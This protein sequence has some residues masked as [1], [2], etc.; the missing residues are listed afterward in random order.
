[1]A[2]GTFQLQHKYW[3]QNVC[4]WGAN[5]NFESD[6][7]RMRDVTVSAVNRGKQAG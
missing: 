5:N 4:I 3:N 6:E 2:R 1:M 7:W